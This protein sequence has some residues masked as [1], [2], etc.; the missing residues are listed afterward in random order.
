MTGLLEKFFSWLSNNKLTDWLSSNKWYTLGIGVCI[1]GI[2]IFLFRVFD[3]TVEGRINFVIAIPVV[4][5]FAI[6]GILV[7]MSLS[8]EG[9]GG[10]GGWGRVKKGKVK[11]GAKVA[12]TINVIT[13]E[14]REG[15]MIPFKI[16]A[17][18]SAKPIG[19]KHKLENDGKFYFVRQVDI[20]GKETAKKEGRNVEQKA[21]ELPDTIYLDPRKYVIPLT[22]PADEDY[23][24]PP[25][26]T[27]QKVAPFALIVAII[28]EWIVY[29]TTRGG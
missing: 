20:K 4:L 12:N 26:T 13:R 19:Q 5:L 9:M 15:K 23:W 24:K 7:V 22:M 29:T 18:H 28:V 14:N 6:G 21:L 25:V 16:T 8:I 17:T 11:L 1:T 2:G 3:L 27:W 10:A